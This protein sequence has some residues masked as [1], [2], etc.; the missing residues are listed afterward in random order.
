[1][2]NWKNIL[3]ICVLGLLITLL[4]ASDALADVVPPDEVRVSYC[5]GVANIN[6]YP[7]YL[8][9]ARVKSA[10][11][12]LPGSNRVLKQGKCLGLNG[13]MEYSEVYALKKYDVKP[14][15]IVKTKE[16]EELKNFD[17]KK[18]K[19]IPHN[20][21]ISPVRLMPQKYQVSE[22]ADIFEITGINSK[23]LNLKNKEV[24]YTYNDKTSERKVYTRQSVR[25]EPRSKT[26]YLNWVII[27]VSSIGSFALLK[28]VGLP[29]KGAN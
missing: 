10:N 7:N 17:T 5:Y 23:S 21:Q 28:K 27:A 25:P 19:L 26:G 14:Q 2:K 3:P 4:P 20:K 12:S 1:M 13:Y 16:G 9:I 8:F 6:K 22:V 24:V 15:E 11:P 29:K 18:S